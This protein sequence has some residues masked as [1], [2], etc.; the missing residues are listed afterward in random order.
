MG[1]KWFLRYDKS[2]EMRFELPARKRDGSGII[3]D[4]ATFNEILDI[5]EEATSESIVTVD[6]G[7]EELVVE[8]QV[9]D[10]ENTPWMSPL[11]TSNHP[12]SFSD[13]AGWSQ[14]SQGVRCRGIS[15]K[16]ACRRRGKYSTNESV[17]HP[18]TL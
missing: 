9:K 10:K 2:K 14:L 13:A 16:R 8:E 17:N 12:K 11:I 5:S 3:E 1:E 6:Q 15:S 7:A 18:Q 4:E